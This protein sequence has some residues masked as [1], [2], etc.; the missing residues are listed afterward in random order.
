[1]NTNERSQVKAN[2]IGWMNINDFIDENDD[3]VR[4]EDWSFLPWPVVPKTEH[5]DTFFQAVS[6]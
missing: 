5:N 3:G 1:M 6:T 2:D 4:G